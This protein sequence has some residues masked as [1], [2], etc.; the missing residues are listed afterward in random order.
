MAAHFRVAGKQTEG[1]GDRT[2]PPV[3]DQE[4][5]RTIYIHNIIPPIIWNNSICPPTKVLVR[6]EL[7]YRKITRT[8]TEQI[9]NAL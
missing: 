2:V 4:F 7:A 6:I 3:R 9:I 5:W 1:A 8:A